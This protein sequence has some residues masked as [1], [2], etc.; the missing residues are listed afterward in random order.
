MEWESFKTAVF[1]TFG[2]LK[3]AKQALKHPE[4]IARAA[5]FAQGVNAAW[6]AATAK[7]VVS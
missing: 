6:Q 5:M 1:T 2:P 3:A 4:N 7:E